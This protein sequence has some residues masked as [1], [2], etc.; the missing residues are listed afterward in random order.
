MA[1]DSTQAAI[2]FPSFPSRIAYL[3]ALLAQ[4]LAR[5]AA[6]ELGGTTPVPGNSAFASGAWADT[7]TFSD[8]DTWKDAA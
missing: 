5:I 6:L 3:E 4:A 8:T 1:S 7:G 2:E